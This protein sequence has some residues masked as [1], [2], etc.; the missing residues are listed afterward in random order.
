M[1]RK[2]TT[3]LGVFLVLVIV[4]VAC[5]EKSD[6]THTLTLAW[7]GLDEFSGS[8]LHTMLEKNPPRPLFDNPDPGSTT[9]DAEGSASMTSTTMWITTGTARVI[10]MSPLILSAVGSSRM[11]WKNWLYIQPR[12]TLR[13]L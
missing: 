9:I 1:T 13:R 3:F 6:L 11:Q 12:N 7:N 4:L 8:E 5:G 2:S 10:K